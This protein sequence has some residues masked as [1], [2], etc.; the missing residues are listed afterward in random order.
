MPMNWYAGNKK[1]A[2]WEFTQRSGEEVVISD[3]YNDK[4]LQG[5]K[6]Y[7]N[8]ILKAA[9][10]EEQADSPSPFSP[11]TLVSSGNVKVEGAA[12]DNFP[13]AEIQLPTMLRVPSTVKTNL[14][15][16]GVQYTADY[17]ERT[18]SSVLLHKCVGKTE[19]TSA[20][21]GPYPTDKAGNA[22][23]WQATQMAPSGWGPYY[24]THFKVLTQSMNLYQTGVWFGA[25]SKYLYFVQL[26]DEIGS[27]MDV[28]KAW[29]DAEEAAGTPVTI[30]YPLETPVTTDITST[31]VGQAILAAKTI[32]KYSRFYSESEIKPYLTINTRTVDS[33]FWREVQ[34]DI[35]AGLG[36]TKYPVGHSFYVYDSAS[37]RNLEFIVLGHDH[38]A[39]AD[40]ALAHTMTLGVKDVW[41]YPNG[42]S[43]PMQF[44]AS[45]ALYY[46]ENGLAA[47][48]YNFTVANQAW[49]AADNGKTFQ[50]TLENAVP[51]GG[52]IVLSMTYNATLEGK[53]VKT[54]ASA[55]STTAIETATLSEGS[56]GTSLGTTDGNNSP[57]MN[58]MHR[59]MFGSN[60]Y[61][62]SAVRQWINSTDAAG[63]VWSPTNKFDRPP[64]WAATYN[65]FLRG[66]PAEFLAVVQP[67]I[68]PCR[69]GSQAEIESLNGD[70]FAS[71]QA[72]T[73][74][75]KF[76]LLSRPEVTGTWY[77]P[78]IKDGSQLAYYVGKTAAERIKRNAIGT[79]YNIW[80]RSPNITNASY[81][82]IIRPDGELDTNSVAANNGIAPAC[83][84]A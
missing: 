10:N 18:G 72:Y 41:S 58:H 78:A 12:A 71:N 26:P 75:D 40:P 79:A 70:E 57:G 23:M 46:A 8:S 38:H 53:N 83:I 33:D 37:S 69:T 17:I 21:W 25:N 68:I 24:C 16:G 30:Y 45:E 61:A 67:A 76:F 27:S 11:W 47:G 14:Y 66:L 81:A 63:A 7:G 64:S 51:A 60:N 39:A 52:Q 56:G 1:I 32:P 74:T 73:V 49:Y 35:R 48:T 20:G 65:G 59:T 9:S 5:T 2:G 82:R 29:L 19:L 62:Q 3:T 55:S 44:D 77:D 36:P 50:F 80:L 28:W 4:L 84:I 31:P 6:I 42:A 13:A 43:R 54:F 34:K 22:Y 15:A